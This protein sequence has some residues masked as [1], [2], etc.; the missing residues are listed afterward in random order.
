[1]ADYNDGFDFGIDD[2]GELQLDDLTY[3]IHKKEGNE[4]KIQLSISRIKS[5]ASN[6][7]YDN[8]GADLELIIGKPC[9]ADTAETGKTMISNALTMDNL[10]KEN[11][12]IIVSE[13]SNN[14]K[15]ISYTIYFKIYQQDSEI[16]SSAT[17]NVLLDL[18]KGV[19]INYGWKARDYECNY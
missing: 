13:I 17:I 3:D 7:F 1:M 11:E 10:W 14:K 5:V 6:W 4:N 15:T 18:V 19:N 9:N 16:P 2:F 12:F 8:A